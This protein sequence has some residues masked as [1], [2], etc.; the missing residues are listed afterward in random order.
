MGS[1][2][3]CR[4]GGGLPCGVRAGEYVWTG[5]QDACWTNAANWTVDGAVA[6][7][8]P[9]WVL[10]TTSGG[11]LTTNGTPADV[12]VFGACASGRTTINL[13][14]QWK[15]DSVVFTNGAPAYTLGTSVGDKAQFLMLG[16]KARIA[17]AEAV[18][19]DQTIQVLSSTY[20]R[21]VNGGAYTVSLYNN[22]PSARL[23]YNRVDRIE[24]GGVPYYYLHGVGTIH[25]NGPWA[26]DRGSGFYLYLTG[27]FILGEPAK[28]QGSRVWSYFS[29][30]VPALGGAPRIIEIPAGCYM[31]TTGGSWSD[32]IVTANENT[33][34]VGGGTILA[35]NHYNSSKLSP[36]FGGNFEVAAGKVL[37]VDAAIRPTDGGVTWEFPGSIGL[38]GSGTLLLHGTNTCVGAVRLHG[39]GTLAVTRVGAAG[40]AAEESCLGTGSE[41]RFHS[42]GTLRYVGETADATDRAFTTT[43]A[44]AALTI[45]FAN[46]GSGAFTLSSHQRMLLANVNGA[47]LRLNAETAP[48]VFNGTF[49]EGQ[50]WRM[51][52]AGAAGVSFPVEPGVPVDL[53][54][55]ARLDVP[56][57]AVIPSTISLLGDATCVVAANRNLTLARLP[58]VPGGRALDF[59]IPE[60]SSVTLAGRP[61]LRLDNVTINGE[62][63][64]TDD[65]GRI[66]RA[67]AVATTVWTSVEVGGEWSAAANW[68]NGR[69]PGTMD[70]VFIAN[71]EVG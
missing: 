42:N 57:D 11:V 31:N 8:P 14:G 39:N 28:T 50:A 21:S 45:T 56:A 40:C 13:D 62:A 17:V 64:Q 43:N 48:I 29:E 6:A 36:E 37:E 49:E 60:D 51:Q 44:T 26:F 23:V 4:G 24:G 66:V 46:G 32:K 27:R 53:A 63:A 54:D 10:A 71:D 61:N 22:S 55:G 69:K 65:T 67:G 12:A 5:A 2:G 35:R 15:I 33:H 20:D 18:T 19:A 9:G 3:R 25:Q 59:I 30:A 52:V 68:Q 70:N 16:L 47:T 34:I 58:Q 7:N 41:V 1:A 38:F